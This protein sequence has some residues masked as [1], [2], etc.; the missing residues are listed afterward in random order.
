MVPPGLGADRRPFD[1]RLKRCALRILTLSS[2][3]PNRAMP[4]FGVFVENRIRKLAATGEAEIR[5]VA[6]IPWFPFRHPFFG[7]YAAWA[8]V[9]YMELRHGLSVVHPRYPL[10]PKISMHAHPFL[11]AGRTLPLL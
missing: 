1:Q 7:R 5:V 8:A 9:P 3:Y 2:L 11:I 10:P 6:P 4:T